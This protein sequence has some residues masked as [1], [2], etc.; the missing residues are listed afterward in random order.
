MNALDLLTQQHR[1]V[2][3][4]FEELRAHPSG[5]ERIRLLGA[6][7]E[8]LTIHM[9]IEELHFFP[10]LRTQGLPEGA[11]TAKSEHD[12][13]RGMLS[14][15][16]QLKQ[17]SPEIQQLLVDLETAVKTHLLIEERD[18]FLW[19]RGR[20]GNEQLEAAGD[21]MQRSA[22]EL[23]KQDILRQAERGESPA[24]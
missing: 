17:T 14:R 24:P 12:Q 20:L 11:D 9:D 7:A 2:S 10:L 13:V 6:L 23:R 18:L 1:E 15:L 4:L 8:L 3:R 16:M 19:A 22:D 5:A 21:A